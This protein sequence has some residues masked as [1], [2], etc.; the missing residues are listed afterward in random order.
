MVNKVD[1]ISRISPKMI[2]RLMRFHWNALEPFNLVGEPATWKSIRVF[3]EAKVIAQDEGRDFFDWSRTSLQAKKDVLDS[4]ERFFVFADLRASEMDI[5]ELR[6]QDMKAAESYIV[7]RYNILFEVLSK[8]DAKGII[9]FDEMTLAPAMIKSQF[10]RII[11]DHAIGDIPLAEGVVCCM[12][13]NESEHSRGVTED[14]VPLVLRR[15]NYFVR[16]PSADEFLEWGLTAGLHQWI[17]G[18]LGFQPHDV[19]R[20]KYDLP[21]SV[22]QPCSRTWAKLSKMLNS[23]ERMSDDEMELVAMGAVGQ[24]TGLQFARYVK[25]AKKIDLDGFIRNPALIKELE[26]DENL[27]LVYAVFAGV[28]EKFRTEKEGKVV[29]PAFEMALHIKKPELGVYLLR[30]MKAV[31]EKKLSRSAGSD[32]II[33]KPLMDKV[34]ERYGKFLFRTTSEDV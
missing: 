11:N 34:V 31:D 5:G 13:G 8:K 3:E 25:A 4:P 16:P 6:L 24:A 21:D 7:F 12:A 17:V 28:V 30:S 18:Y 1:T 10:Y 20:I 9:F 27:S 29:R 22:G 33:D 32:K 26:T 19:H 23:N 2:Q 14:P 15:H